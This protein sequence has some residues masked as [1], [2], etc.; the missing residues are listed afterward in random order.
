MVDP[1]IAPISTIENA[2]AGSKV[3]TTGVFSTELLALPT[4]MGSSLPFGAYTRLQ[5]SYRMCNVV[6]LTTLA[7]VWTLWIDG[8]VG[9]SV[10]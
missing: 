9:P 3:D 5:G 1:G 4:S 2:S 7:V 8:A 10:L 6:F